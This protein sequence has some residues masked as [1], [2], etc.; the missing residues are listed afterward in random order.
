MLRYLAFQFSVA[1]VLQV[2]E[3]LVCDSCQEKR[4]T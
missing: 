3:E 1:I 4:R 2:S